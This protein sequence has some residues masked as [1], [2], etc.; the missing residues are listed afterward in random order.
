MIQPSRIAAESPNADQA[1]KGRGLI[2]ALIVLAASACVVLVL[3]FLG[4]AQ[5]DPYLRESLALQGAIDHGGQLFR[6]NCAGCHG[7]A[8]QGL[9]GPELMGI[10]ERFR[11]PTLVHQIISGDTPPMPSFEIEPQSMADLLAYLH[12]LS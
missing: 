5:T 10:T 11:D 9:V 8:G 4:N 12:T 3:W 6:I 7:L 2:R 1:D